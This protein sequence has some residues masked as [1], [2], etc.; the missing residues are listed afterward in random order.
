MLCYFY[1]LFF[2][3]EKKK[4]DAYETKKKN[5]SNNR[6]SS[7]IV[8]EELVTFVYLLE[9]LILNDEQDF[10][11]FS[12]NMPE[13]MHVFLL[14]ILYTSRFVNGGEYV[15]QRQDSILFFSFSFLT[16]EKNRINNRIA[17]KRIN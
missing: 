6:F 14:Y 2:L 16:R 4:Q 8:Y 1:C 17:K 9:K 11:F 7:R 12:R 10:F 3:R 5:M 15:R 13:T